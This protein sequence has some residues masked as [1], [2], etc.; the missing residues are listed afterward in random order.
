MGIRSW[1]RSLESSWPAEA[2]AGAALVGPIGDPYWPV[3]Y[4]TPNVQHLYV[5]ELPGAAGQGVNAPDV[6]SLSVAQLWATQPHLRTVVSFLAENAAQ[7]GLHT[8]TRA[9]ENDRVRDRDSA[10]AK[11]LRRPNGSCSQYDL[12]YSLV[13]DLAL[14]DTA[15]WYVQPTS[16]APGGFEL[17]RLPPAWVTPRADSA[18]TVGSYVVRGDGGE[19]VL[20]ASDVIDFTGYNPVDPRR[21]SPAVESLRPLLQ[22]QAEAARYRAQ[23]WKNGA[24]ATSVLERPA[25]APS[26]T[27]EQAQQFREDWR[28]QF[29]GRGPRAG[30][31][32]ILPDG[33][34][35]T[36]VG[37]S[38][39]DSQWL[40]GTKL[41]LVQVAAA[42]H[43]TPAMVGSTE[44]VTYANMREFRRMLYGETLGPLLK[45]IED[46]LNA[47]LLPMLG[48][49]DDT[50][51]E[52]NVEAKLRGSFEEQAAVLQA[53]T[54]G[55]WMTR[56][57]A[58]K[59]NNLPAVEGGDEL[60]VPLNLS[61]NAEADTEPDPTDDEPE[62]PSVE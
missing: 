33:M 21:G 53:A 20:P 4:M 54:G 28:S 25:N 38:A 49:G 17:H 29:T 2:A 5:N 48:A 58:R 11:V 23:H 9:G 26:W 22:E 40:E 3:S 30:G 61:T 24:R 31:T 44:G 45:R 37:F 1:F 32:P 16:A 14:Y 60:I 6:Y 51:V 7:L 57:E 34:K 18:F 56:N 12:L 19:V 39:T 36:Q 43:V 13:G 47:F 8:Y 35:L 27:P 41:A 50:Y 10:V 62:A 55:P 52:F 46:R 15:Y 59:V 42:Y